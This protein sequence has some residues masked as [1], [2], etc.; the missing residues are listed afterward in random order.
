MIEKNV[1]F[2]M[3][4]YPNSDHSISFDGARK[5]LFAAITEFMLTSLKGQHQQQQE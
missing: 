2:T 1:P 4:A 5:H 3:M